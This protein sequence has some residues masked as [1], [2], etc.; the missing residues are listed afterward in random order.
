MST[1]LT[2]ECP[3][4]DL[5]YHTFRFDGPPGDVGTPGIAGEPGTPGQHGAR[6]AMVYVPT[7]L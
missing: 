2:N 7:F 1:N 3:Y 4:V 6:G 5:C